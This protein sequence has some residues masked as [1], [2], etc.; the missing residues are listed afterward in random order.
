MK[1]VDELV[2]EGVDI[3]A[4]GVRTDHTWICV[5]DFIKRL[6]K[7]SNQLFMADVTTFEEGVLAASGIDFCWNNAIW[8]Y[9]L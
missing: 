1:E 4:L 3:I 2:A 6:R 7:I 9:T 5:V 8:L